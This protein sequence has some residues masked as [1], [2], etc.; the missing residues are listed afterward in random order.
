MWTEKEEER[1]SISF[2]TF[3]DYVCSQAKQDIKDPKHHRL[4]DETGYS[5]P[6][7]DL[8]S[9]SLENQSPSLIKWLDQNTQFV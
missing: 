1:F 7:E 9:I 5:N 4:S 2:N 3:Y 6:Q 8:D